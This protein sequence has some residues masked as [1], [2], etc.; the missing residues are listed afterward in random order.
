MKAHEGRCWADFTV[1]MGSMVLAAGS[2]SPVRTA[3]SHSM[4]LEEA[5]V[6]RHGITNVEEHHVSWHKFG[7]VDLAER[8]AA[9]GHPAV[10][11]T[12]MKALHG[13]FRSVLIHEAEPDTE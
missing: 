1:V 5:N 10:T 11:D 4:Y 8:A 2:D 6:G 9:A 7:D 3:S 13:P 12:R